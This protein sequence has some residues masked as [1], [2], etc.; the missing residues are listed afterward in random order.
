VRGH[1]R[2]QRAPAAVLKQ[3]PR[4]HTHGSCACYTKGPFACLP[5]SNTTKHLRLINPCSDLRCD[6][7]SRRQFTLRPVRRRATAATLVTTLSEKAHL[8]RLARCPRA[9]DS[10]KM[11]GFVV[12]DFEDCQEIFVDKN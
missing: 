7:H 1:A 5:S 4:K 10:P 8:T 2:R 12:A 3:V 11:L 9:C 6:G